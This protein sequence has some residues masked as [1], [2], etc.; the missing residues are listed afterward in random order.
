MTNIKLIVRG[1]RVRVEVDGILTSGAVGIPVTIQ[2]DSAWDGLTKNLVC[3]SGEWGP[4]VKPRTIANIDTAATVAHE[5]MIAGNHL[6]LGVEGRNADGTIVIPTA[7]ADC[8]EIYPGAGVSRDPSAK[9]TL[10]IWA[11][12]E[13]QINDLK[14]NETQS[15]GNNAND[16]CQ[17]VNAAAV[18]YDRNVKAVNH[19]G[20]SATAPENTIPAFILSKKNGFNYVECDVCFSS[21]GVPVLSHSL[22]IDAC[23]NGTGRVDAYTYA[24]LLAFDFGSWKSAEYAG[25]RIA[26]FDEFLRVCKGLGLYPYVDF[27]SS[28]QAQIE[29]I[30]R[31]VK[32]AGMADKTTYL[33]NLSILS[34]IKNA[35]PSARLGVLHSSVDASVIETA[36]ALKTDANEVFID[37]NYANI[38]DEAVQ[39]CVDAGIPLELY[40]INS[41][42][43][44]EEMN[45]YVSG[46]TSDHL[47]AGKV[48]YDK[49]MTYTAPEVE[50]VPATGISLSDTSLSFSDSAAKTITATVEPSDTT[51]RVAWVSSDTEVATVSNGVITPVGNG[52][53][54]ITAT[55]GAVSAQCAVT[56]SIANTGGNDDPDTGGGTDTPETGNGDLLYNWDFTK[57]LVDTV[58][59]NTVT[60][61]DSGITQ[62]ANGLSISAANGYATISNAFGN[63]LNRTIEIDIA[64]VDRQSTAHGRF[65]AVRP[66]TSGGFD[67]GFIYRNSGKW[68]VYCGGWFDSTVTD[69]TALNGKTITI[70]IFGAGTSADQATFAVYLNG[71]LLA[72][73]TAF[74]Y[75]NTDLCI[76][77]PAGSSLYNCTVTGMRVYDGV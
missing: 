39:L 43:M 75:T 59:G 50:E 67:S 51:D 53:C 73:S 8:G 6:Y 18:D 63:G 14:K 7:W 49:Y 12:L 46:V 60:L 66:T 41:E 40:T 35:D 4:A 1:A 33:G 2:Y 62:D 28:T 54:T 22:Y 37:T 19:R 72:E 57:S 69:P 11:Q 70:K 16:S 47:I 74:V 24:E 68:A 27:K 31:M 30:V 55:A 42:T 36:V 17:N 13:Q 32:N 56:V 71:E 25:T 58:S 29:T 77:S 23:S 64:S 20:Y 9:P 65:V 5:V 21:D 38:T 45:G 61:C 52:S 34:N 15:G 44:I 10:P 48:L 3:T 26:T 76:G